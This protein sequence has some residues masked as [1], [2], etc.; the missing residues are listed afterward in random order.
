MWNMLLGEQGR[1]GVVDWESAR[2]NGLPLVDFFYAMADAVTIARGYTDRSKAFKACFVAGGT[3][4]R[5]VSQF[6]TRLRRI[7]QLPDEMVEFCFHACWL[8]H[9][10]NEHRAAGPSDPRPFLKIVQWLA[11]NR[12]RVGRWLHE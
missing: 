10:A 7:V 3:Y 12:S 6:A 2:E 8:H 4:A 5:M 9:A 11:L 1:L